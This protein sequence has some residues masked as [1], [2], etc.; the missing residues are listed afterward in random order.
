MR[1]V[2]SIHDGR[3]SPVLDAATQFLLLHVNRHNEVRRRE[4]HTV[5]GA[6]A[7]KAGRIVEL[8]PHVLICGAVSRLLEAMLVSAGVRLVPN[9]CGSVDTWL[10]RSLRAI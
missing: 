10:P 2:L 1:V 8:G 3:I 9:T 4:V 6:A 7:V 5:S